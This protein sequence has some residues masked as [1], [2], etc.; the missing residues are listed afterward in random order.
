MGNKSSSEFMVRY[1]NKDIMEKLDSLYK[2]QTQTYEQA[3]KTNGRVTNLEKKSIG[4]WA[5]NNMVKA[6]M[7]VSLL[8]SILI[9]DSRDVLIQ[10]LIKVF[11][12]L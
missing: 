9:S 11:T 4:Y 8:L 1:T 7:I 10:T 2:Q 6:V 3:K 5:S 12:G